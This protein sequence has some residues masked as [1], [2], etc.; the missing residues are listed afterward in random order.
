MAKIILLHNLIIK[1]TAENFIE[2]KIVRKHKINLLWAQLKIAKRWK[3]IAKK[4]GNFYQN[5]MIKNVLSFEA[6]CLNSTN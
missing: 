2:L 4:K 6:L 3:S 1:R 5:T